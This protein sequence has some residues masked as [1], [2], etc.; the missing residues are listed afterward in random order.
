MVS[1]SAHC[2]TL[3]GSSPDLFHPIKADFGFDLLVSVDTEN[4]WNLRLGE[5]KESF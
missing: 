5:M 3:A 2:L 4:K 1:D